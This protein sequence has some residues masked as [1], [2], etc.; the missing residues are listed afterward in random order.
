MI[1]EDTFLPCHTESLD[2]TPS[3]LMAYFHN[4]P[5]FPIIRKNRI[6]FLCVQENDTKRLVW[7]DSFENENLPEFSRNGYWQTTKQRHSASFPF[8][9]KDLKNFENFFFLSTFFPLVLTFKML[10]NTNIAS[11]V[12][13]STAHGKTPPA[14]IGWEKKI[15]TWN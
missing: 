5:Y 8:Q 1:F 11:K 3:P 6:F 9:W 2:F 4:N 13:R 7:S 12:L 15:F 14:K 10:F